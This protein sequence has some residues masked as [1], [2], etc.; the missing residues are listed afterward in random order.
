[1][2]GHRL[3]QVR[4]RRSATDHLRLQCIARQLHALDPVRDEP[5]ALCK[6]GELAE[7][8]GQQGG[9]VRGAGADLLASRLGLRL[10]FAAG[11]LSQ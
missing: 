1:M 3:H 4:G 7:P 2:V 5:L 9:P 6:V 8:L 11:S 10:L